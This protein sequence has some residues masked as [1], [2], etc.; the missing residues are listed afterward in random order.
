[1]KCVFGPD[2]SVLC[3]IISTHHQPAEKLTHVAEEFI[4]VTLRY[5]EWMIEQGSDIGLEHFL[6]IESCGVP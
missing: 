4:A 3:D 2:V 6:P 1:M 5:H